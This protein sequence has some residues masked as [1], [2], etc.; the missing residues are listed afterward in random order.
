MSNTKVHSGD[1]LIADPFLKD[2]SF[3]RSVVLLCEADVDGALGFILN[4]QLP[5]LLGELV[6]EMEGYEF[7][8]M[9]GGP[10]RMDTL[11]FLHA[12]PDVIPGGIA[13]SN[14]IYWGGDFPM[15]L[16]SIRNGIADIQ[17]LRLF[18]GQSG[19]AE[20]QLQS[21]I[22]DNTW[23]CTS[24]K[25]NI[26]FNPNT[27]DIWKDAVKLMGKKYEEVINYPIDPSLN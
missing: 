14:G 15:M 2:S 22:S 3:S 1:F 6:Q 27:T 16:D 20:N 4:K 7:P 23:L 18:L 25:Q 9:Y 8:V 19:W 21:E 26:V 10:V 17:N 12:I 24:A 11:H 5:H 13:V